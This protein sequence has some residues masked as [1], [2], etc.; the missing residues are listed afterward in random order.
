MSS[1]GR[2]FRNRNPLVLVVGRRC[3]WCRPCSAS[4]H[5]FT[6]GRLERHAAQVLPAQPARLVHLRVVDRGQQQGQPPALPAVYIIGGSSS[7]EAIVSGPCLAAEVRQLGGPRIDGLGPRLDQP[8]LRRE[9]GGGRQRAA[10]AAPGCSSASTSVASRPVRRR[11]SGQVHGPRPSCSRARRCRA[12]C[13]R[14]AARTS[15][16]S[17]SC[18]ASSRTSR[19]GQARRQGP[20]ARH[21][22]RDAVRAAP[23]HDGRTPRRQKQ[24][25]VRPVEPHALSRCSSRTSSSTCRCCR[26]SWRSCRQRGVRIVIVELPTNERIIRGRFDYAIRQYEVPARKLAA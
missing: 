10:R 24:R 2:G 26:S 8:E 7:R 25:M 20:A 4:R 11:T 23:V 22:S 15:T 6:I 21:A 5:F 1:F 12:T 17:R 18:R 16:R 13:R 9:P 14:R 19:A 3:C